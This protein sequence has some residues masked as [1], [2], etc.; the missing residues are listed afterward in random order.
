[1]SETDIYKKMSSKYYDECETY[2]LENK[3]L[4]NENQLLKEQLKI[5]KEDITAIYNEMMSLDIILKKEQEDFEDIEV[6]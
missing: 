6:I 1:M 2:L 5:L 3:R 4:I